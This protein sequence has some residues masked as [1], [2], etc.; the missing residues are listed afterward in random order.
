MCPHRRSLA[1]RCAAT[2]ANLETD[3]L[4]ESGHSVADDFPHEIGEKVT[5][6]I[7]TFA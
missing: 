7:K 3:F 5:A 6:W 4:G 2:F 1:K